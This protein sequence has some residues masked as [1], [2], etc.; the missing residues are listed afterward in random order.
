MSSPFCGGVLATRPRFHRCNSTVPT[1]PSEAAISH[2]TGIA[3][4]NHAATPPHTS[5][6]PITSR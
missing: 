6:S 1:T 4:P 3:A 5:A 2:C